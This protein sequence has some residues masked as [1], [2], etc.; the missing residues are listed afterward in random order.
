MSWFLAWCRESW[1]RLT[2]REI[3]YGRHARRPG[4]AT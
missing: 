4:S 1:L 2:R 3:T